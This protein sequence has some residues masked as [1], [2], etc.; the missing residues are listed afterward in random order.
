MWG[1][2]M[3]PTTAGWPI[4]SRFRVTLLA[5]GLALPAAAA[6]SHDG[7]TAPGPSAD[8]GASGLVSL[9]ALQA[10]TLDCS[11][12]GKTV[13]LT[14]GGAAYL[15]VPQFATSRAANQPVSYAIGAGTGAV[16][17]IQRPG[18]RPTLLSTQSSG[19]R[20]SSKSRAGPIQQRVDALLRASDRKHALAFRSHAIASH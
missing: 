13:A 18:A 19:Q 7:P 1:C 10:V 5:A 4:L 17:A 2:E 3:K 20:L 6:C 11:N 15:V 16:A 12:G 9:T 8:C 14:G